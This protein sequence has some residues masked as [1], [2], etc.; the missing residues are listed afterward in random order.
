MQLRFVGH[1]VR[2]P[3]SSRHGVKTDQSARRK[4]FVSRISTLRYP[5]VS[6]C[7]AKRNFAGRTSQGRFDADPLAGLPI[8]YSA[9]NC[10]NRRDIL[11]PEN[12]RK[13]GIALENRCRM[14]AQGYK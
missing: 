2:C 3:A 11:V 4:T 9:T 5:A 13:P 12:G 1:E 7:L 8:T 10:V 6:T 14:I